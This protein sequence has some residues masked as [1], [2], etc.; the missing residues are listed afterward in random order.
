MVDWNFISS[1]YGA[2]TLLMAPLMAKSKSNSACI[3]TLCRPRIY[4]I[5]TTSSPLHHL[6]A[7]PFRVSHDDRS[8]TSSISTCPQ[9]TTSQSGSCHNQAKTSPRVIPPQFPPP[10]LK[11]ADPF[12]YALS[13]T[14]PFASEQFSVPSGTLQPAEAQDFVRADPSHS[15]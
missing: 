12:S 1:A 15:R 11:Q 5:G 7:R 14:L 4:W 3:S 13:F 9:R 8:A 6:M 2:G 10:R